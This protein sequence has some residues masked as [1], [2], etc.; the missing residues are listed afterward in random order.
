MQHKE[1][2][3]FPKKSDVVIKMFTDKEYFLNKYK[4]LGAK[5]I[6]L[7]EHKKD[8]DKFSIKVS[9]EVPADVPLPSF[10]QKFIS[11]NMTVV[12]QDSWDAKT[13][14]GRLDINI[15][16]IPATITC[17]MELKDEGAGSVN[18]LN[19]TVKVGIPLIG[20]KLEQVLVDDIK[21]KTG[22]DTAEGVKQVANYS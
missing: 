11:A 2:S 22:P 8:G 16:G 17:D 6:Q 21:K 3:V 9:R 15:K 5:N 19:W 14:K 18:H 4:N 1:K 12:Q 10:A 13:K 20:G 7:L